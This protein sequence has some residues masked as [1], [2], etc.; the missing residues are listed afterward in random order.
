MGLHP[1]QATDQEASSGL[2]IAESAVA[3]TDLDP[4][5]PAAFVE[6]P[7]ASYGRCQRHS[8]E[9]G[10]PLDAKA[11]IGE[12]SGKETQIESN[13]V[14]YKDPIAKPGPHV[15]NDLPESWGFRDLTRGYPMNARR[16]DIAARVDQG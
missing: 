6:P 1:L 2:R 11:C 5:A 7:S 14:P 3:P 9:T 10:D 12:L 13:V 4:E 8:A 15:A 16:A